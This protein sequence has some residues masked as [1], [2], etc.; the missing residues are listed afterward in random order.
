M[1]QRRGQRLIVVEIPGEVAQ[2]FELNNLAGS[3]VGNR[4]LTKR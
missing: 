1:K 4:W 2:P 3:D